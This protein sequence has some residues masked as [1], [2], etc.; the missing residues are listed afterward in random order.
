MQ[1][2][3]I[4][5]GLPVHEVAAA[6]R[7][8]PPLSQT[9]F[10]QAE[11]VGAWLAQEHVDAVYS[12]TMRRAIQTAE[13][14]A[15][16]SGLA[17]TSLEGIVEF[18]RNTGEYMPMEQLKRTDYARWR[19]FVDGGY[20]NQVDIGAF[21]AR[22]VDTL[23]GII[24]AHPSQNVAVFCHGGVVNVWSTHVLEMSPQLFC[25]VRYASVSR[26]LCARS[27]QRNLVSIN[28]TGHLRELDAH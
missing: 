28:E 21:R 10:Q 26:Y 6:G 20:G 22:V 1:L 13:P 9:G 18:D 15:R 5:H 25:D 24:G 27:G 11:A 3:L 2:I 16:H 19:A 12:S 23:E 14:F 17:L 8:D 4:R 7:A